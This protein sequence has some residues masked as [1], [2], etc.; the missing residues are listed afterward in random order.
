VTFSE[1]AEK[2]RK[3]LGSCKDPESCGKYGW[4]QC[5]S[6]SVAEGHLAEMERLHTSLLF[7]LAHRN[8]RLVE[9]AE[10]AE[11]ALAAAKEALRVALNCKGSYEG[12]VAERGGHSA[13]C[14][15]CEAVVR[16]AA[17]GDETA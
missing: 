8:D 9:R 10:R 5:L 4:R 2:V 1:H 17:G 6:C 3:S 16:A 13:M 14:P 15:N 7:E 12:T 11:A